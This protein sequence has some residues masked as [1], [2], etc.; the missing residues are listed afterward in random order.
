MSLLNKMLND[1]ENR[2]GTERIPQPPAGNLHHSRSTRAGSIRPIT[3]V[4]LVAGVIIAGLVIWSQ[5]HNSGA[6]PPVAPAINFPIANSP[7]VKKDLVAINRPLMTS[8]VSSIIAVAETASKSSAL[9]QGATLAHQDSA[10]KTE[11]PTFKKSV[12][13]KRTHKPV[14]NQVTEKALSADSATSTP[15]SFKV[16]SPQ[17]QSDNL[18][19]QAI[20]FIQ[21]SRAAEAQQALRKSLAANAANRNAR[22]LLANLLADSGNDTEAETLLREGLKSA[23][24]HS[25]FNL[26]LAHLQFTQ[27]KKDE[28]IATMEQ[29]L[30]N[31]GDDAEYHAFLA[32]LLQNQGRHPEAIQHYITA[33]RS[34]PSMPNWLIGVGVSL[35]A[36]DKKSDAAEA[37]Q[38]A[39]DTGELSNEVVQFA[40]QQLKVMRQSNQ[41]SK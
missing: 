17:Q 13:G 18:Y 12:V 5:Y 6:H 35:Q 40:E 15:S 19:M 34:N 20:S 33:L 32:G 8:P 41:S 24:K 9:P 38:R 4:M 30:A 37:F 28:A 36:T 11:M 1:I 29:G 16:I 22:Q 21:Q 10:N 26:A 7:S 25:G 2:Q 27:G 39:I 3:A 31:A 14:V 23:P